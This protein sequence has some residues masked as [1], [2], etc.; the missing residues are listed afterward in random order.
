MV[1]FLH[2]LLV[3]YISHAQCGTGLYKGV[4]TNM[5]ESQGPSWRLATTIRLCT[6]P[7]LII[8]VGLS[9]S[10]SL[11]W[12]GISSTIVFCPRL[13]PSL[14]SLRS[15]LFYHWVCDIFF[16]PQTSLQGADSSLLSPFFPKAALME[17]A[18]IIQCQGLLPNLWNEMREA[19]DKDRWAALGRKEQAGS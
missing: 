13:S 2:I 3:T 8:G 12:V 19:R 15:L 14:S 1:S 11:L 10:S 6:R 5:Q 4:N 9:S 7:N 17:S 16:P 18:F